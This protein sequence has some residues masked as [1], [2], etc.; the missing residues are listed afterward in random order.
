[1]S[2]PTTDPDVLSTIPVKITE[3]EI[4]APEFGAW[5]TYDFAG[6]SGQI[7][8]VLPQDKKRARAVIRASL[9]NVY[10]GSQAQVRNQIDPAV[11]PVVSGQVANGSQWEITAQSALWAIGDPGA[12]LVVLAERYQ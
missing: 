7:V 4:D 10:V 11:G 12:R 5:S 9:G 2:I 1:M 8:Q 3:T 6:F